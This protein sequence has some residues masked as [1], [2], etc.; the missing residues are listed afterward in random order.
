MK[1]FLIEKSEQRNLDG[2]IRHSSD[3]IARHYLG[4][5][6]RHC[7]PIQLLGSTKSAASLK[8]PGA[9]PVPN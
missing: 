5:Q 8:T 3:D 4:A 1:K 6:I 9:Q 2:V 7:N